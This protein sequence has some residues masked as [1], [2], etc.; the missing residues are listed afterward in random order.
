M[1]SLPLSNIFHRKM[2]TVMTS[3][4]VA[5]GVALVVLTVG[6]VH[7][8]L[9]DQGHRNAAVTAEIM[10]NPPGAGF[11][12][13][14]ST[15][16]SMPTDV[17][18]KLRAI[19]GVSEAVPVGRY[20]HGLGVVDGV[21]YSSFSKVSGLR[22]IEG[23]PALAGDEAMVDRVVQG[24]RKLKIGDTIQEFDRPFKVVGIY[25]P[26]SL[27]RIKVPLSTLQNSM[28]RPGLCSTIFVKVADPSE[29][30]EVAKRIQEQFPKN[31]IFMTRDLPV[32]YAT[33]IPAFQTFLTVVVALSVIVSSLVVLLTMYTTVTEQTR[34]IGILKSLGASR[35]WIASEI[36][37]EALLITLAGVVAGLAISIAGKYAVQR[38]TPL[39][40]ELEPS[41]LFYALVFGLLS[42]SLGALYP[43]ARAANQDP[44]AALS[45]E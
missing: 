28:N 40:I 2:R 15:N 17:V 8:F 4:G 45:Y 22:V 35:Q 30:D 31:N 5:L 34:Q 18:D 43:A 29:Q 20:T 37:K 36:E 14:L 24:S 11:G 1:D 27:G 12:F 10:L 41:W 33:G 39:S 23:R 26:E 32:L 42:G 25:E 44:I 19:P 16:L 6:L 21:D 13:Q 9:Y 38:F 3:A 7:G